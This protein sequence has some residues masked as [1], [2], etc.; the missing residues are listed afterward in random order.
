MNNNEQT[1][2]INIENNKPRKKRFDSIGTPDSPFRIL[3]LNLIKKTD[4]S[5]S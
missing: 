1:Q 5:T 3:L 4:Y 2:A